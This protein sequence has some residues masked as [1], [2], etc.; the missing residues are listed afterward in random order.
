MI[1]RILLLR[2]LVSGVSLLCRSGWQT[3]SIRTIDHALPQNLDLLLQK[4][5]TLPLPLTF[6]FPLPVPLLPLHHHMGVL[7][8]V[9]LQLLY[10][11]SQLFLLFLVFFF[12][13][14]HFFLQFS[15]F[16]CSSFPKRPLRLPILCLS[17]RRWCIDGRF[18]TRLRLRR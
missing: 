16:R 11:F 10:A 1:S 13:A 14:S 9:I 6:H 3:D 2:T 5:L 15:N 7:I 17:F 4:L 8:H 12:H 18:P